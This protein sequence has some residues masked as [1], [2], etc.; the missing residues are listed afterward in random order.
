[1]TDAPNEPVEK[2][3]S[4]TKGPHSEPAG[5]Q[6]G[7][8]TRRKLKFLDGLS[9]LAVLLLVLEFWVFADHVFAAISLWLAII[10]ILVAQILKLRLSCP[11]CGGG[12]YRGW[13][14]SYRSKVPG[15]CHHCGKALP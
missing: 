9:A 14:Y 8:K 5:D 15:E 11:A 13:R 1:V 6:P 4:D 10:V 12:V 7:G 3:V 2:P